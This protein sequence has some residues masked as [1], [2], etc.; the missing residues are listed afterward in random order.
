MCDSDITFLNYKLF[1]F[2]GS[3]KKAKRLVSILL[4]SCFWLTKD[5]EFKQHFKRLFIMMMKRL[6]L[7]L[8]YSTTLKLDCNFGQGK[9]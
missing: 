3:L 9:Y 4:F 2:L 5:K 6:D 7:K 8:L 1:L